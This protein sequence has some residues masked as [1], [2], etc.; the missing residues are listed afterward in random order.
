MPGARYKDFRLGDSSELLAE[1]ILNSMAF[2]TRVPRQEDIGYDFFCVLSERDGKMVKAGP[3]FTVQVKSSQEK[4]IYEKD[5]EVEWIKKQE[6]PFFICVAN[7]ASLSVDIYS[8]WNM[9]TGF[10]AKNAQKI[11]LIPGGPNDNYQEVRTKEDRSV[12][13]IPLGKPILHITAEDVMS[14][15]NVV[16]LAGILH[17]WVTMDRENVVNRHAEMFWIIGPR[18]W[19]TNQPLSK[20]K[21]WITAF[22]W[23]AKNLPKCQINFSRSATALRLVYR[24]AYGEEGEKSEELH[25]EIESLEAVI[26]SHVKYLE[27]LAKQVLIQEISMEL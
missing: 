2:T 20:S 24:W 12:Q 1:F 13:E 15:E 17:E 3:F 16:V 8:T 14:E 18:Y 9:H 22:F 23:N 10:L 5:Y 25:S 21:E 11:I 4:I 6:N 27:P 7:R 26:K 19:E